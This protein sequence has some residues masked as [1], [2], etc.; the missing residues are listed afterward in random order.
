MSS[1]HL[2]EEGSPPIQSS[3]GDYEV[4]YGKPPKS[5]QFKKGNT[6][7]KGRKKGSKNLKTIV[8]ETLGM[9]V[10]V[11]T[12]G[13]VKT[14][15]KFEAG[16]HQLATKHSQGDPKAIAKAIELFER[17]GPKEDPEGPPPEKTAKDHSALKK[18]LAMQDIIHS[19]KAESGDV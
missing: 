5:T 16:L 12:A 6:K 18:Y 3:E 9:K 19:E 15:S 4:G 8:N 17:Y 10:K 7:G 11:K 1:D 13:K 14:I 2:P